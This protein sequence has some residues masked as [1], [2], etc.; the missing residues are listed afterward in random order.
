MGKMMKLKMMRMKM[1]EWLE[2]KIIKKLNKHL[3]NIIF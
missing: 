1:K 3:L 2:K